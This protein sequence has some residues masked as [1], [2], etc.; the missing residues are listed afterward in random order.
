MSRSA[1]SYIF[2]LL[3][4][5]ISYYITATI[6]LQLDAVSG[7]ATLVWPPTGIALA[8]LL[9]FGARLWPAIFF[10]AL[11]VNYHTGAP[12]IAAAGIAIGNTLEAL[13]AAYLLNRIGFGKSL[14]RLVDVFTLIFLAA[15]GSTMISATIGVS[16]LLLTRVITLTATR[17]TW[18]AWWVGDMLGDLV[19]APF[20]LV[21]WSK[22]WSIRISIKNLADA[23]LFALMLEAIYLLV[24][25]GVFGFDARNSPLTYLT[26]LPLIWASLK[27]GQSGATASTFLLS[28]LAIWSTAQGYGPF[29]GKSLLENLYYLQT[30]IAVASA[31]TLTIGASVS[32]RKKFETYLTESKQRFRALIENSYDAITLVTSEGIISYISPST[33]RILGYESSECVGINMINLI[34]PDDKEVSTKLFQLFKKPG[35]IFRAEF[36]LLHKDNHF[37]WIEGVA[38]NLLH[39]AGVNAI[40]I[41]YRDITVRKKA[42]EEV[43][44]R[45]E[46]F[47]ALADNSPD[48]VSRFD[49][50]L[51]H[52]FVNYSVERATSI[53]VQMFIGKTDEEL[54]M[55][56]ENVDQWK[57]N[58]L[59]VFKSGKA[60]TIEFDFVSK[61]GVKTYYQARLMPEFA[62][63]GSIAYVL[64]VSR[65]VTDLRLLGQRLADERDRLGAIID[66]MEEGLFVVDKNQKI[67]L[68][69]NAARKMLETTSDELIGKDLKQIVTILQGDKELSLEERP[70]VKVIRTGQA[71]VT[72]LKDDLYY[73]TP[74]GKKFPVIISVSPLADGDT[75]GAINVFR[76]ITEQKALDKM[77]SEFLSVAA[78]QLRSPLGSMRWNIE[79]LLSGKGDPL[80]EVTK[81]A[82]EQIYKSDLRMILLVNDLLNVSRIDAGKVVKKEELLDVFTEL[83]RMIAEFDVEA[84]ARQITISLL[85]REESIPKIFFDTNQFHEIFNNLISN[86]IKYNK[87]EGKV[88]ITVSTDGQ[89]VVIEVKDNGIGISQDDQS[90]IFSKFFRASNALLADTEGTGLGLYVVKSYIEDRGGSVRLTSEEGKGTIVNINLPVAK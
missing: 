21:L 49:R 27:Y 76:D 44:K 47:K 54:G 37:R 6:G 86:A 28:T 42:E 18:I 57:E 14:E 66:S 90:K 88:L 87:P 7:F 23:G 20:I 51:R 56:K 16:S 15:L 32:E 40:V 29:T 61:K 60:R 83:K 84:K 46:E 8:A 63:D 58:I 17:D 2:G 39:E 43:H 73:K 81:K 62:K 11:L 31:T 10:A 67:T 1:L 38:V 3:L 24:F 12:I 52:I 53:P 30:F 55:P 9:I 41:N 34:H 4:L 13:L 48:L 33:K 64:G 85:K 70:I 72:R 36:R 22:R 79:M 65:D 19:I 71:I 68:I 25:R 45:G 75:T 78:H 77:K 80:G 74:N 89:S 69:N 5:F 26:L 59:E 82:I 50:N 35:E